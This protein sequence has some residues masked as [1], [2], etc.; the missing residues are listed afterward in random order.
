MQTSNAKIPLEIDGEVIYLDP[1]SAEGKAL[2]RIQDLDP[3]D[4]NQV[5]TIVEEG[6]EID[7]EAVW[8]RLKQ[9]G[10]KIQIPSSNS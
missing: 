5:I 3:D 9:R 2:Q 6:Q 8:E 1:N 4:P 10:Y 7:V